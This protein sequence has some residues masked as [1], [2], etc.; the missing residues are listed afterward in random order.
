[1]TDRAWISWGVGE[2]F[3]S[4]VIR[5]CLIEGTKLDL[6]LGREERGHLQKSNAAEESKRQPLSWNQAIRANFQAGLTKNAKGSVQKFSSPI[7]NLHLNAPKP[8]LLLIVLRGD[9]LEDVGVRFTRA[10]WSWYRYRVT[11]TARAVIDAATPRTSGQG[12]QRHRPSGYVP[13]KPSNL[14]RGEREAGRSAAAPLPET[15]AGSSSR[16]PL[17]TTICG[18]E[19]TR[20]S[21][22]YMLD[23]QIRSELR[24]I[25]G[26]EELPLEI[27]STESRLRRA[28]D[29][30]WQ[31]P[32]CDYRSSASSTGKERVTRHTRF[33]HP[34]ITNP[35][36][37]W[38][39][40]QDLETHPEHLV[41][42]ILQA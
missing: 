2:R 29:Y 25:R 24:I 1:M 23:V 19:N 39:K 10:S 8:P 4:S 37:A 41:T 27:I 5:P 13:N 12:F 9:Y 38:Q 42:D 36:A 22:Q 35:N 21:A 30:M 31:C 7:R 14:N 26:R 34:E 33:I 40:G 6:R 20:F 11:T 28:L 3:W 15:A 16:M 17:G 32:A 18:R